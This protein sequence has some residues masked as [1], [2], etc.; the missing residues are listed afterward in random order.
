[1]AENTNA[2]RVSPMRTYLV[3]L[4]GITAIAAFFRYFLLTEIPPGLYPDEAMNGVDALR[5]LNLAD[6]RVFYEANN[7]REGLFMNIQAIAIQIFGVSAWTLRAV[8]ALFGTLAVPAVW[9]LAREVALMLLPA[10]H[11]DRERLA[12][13]FAL[14]SAFVLAAMTWHIHF[15]RIGFRAILLPLLSALT[16]AFILR[17]ERRRSRVDAVS[18]G[19]GFGLLF[20]T[21]IAA[22]ILPVLVIVLAIGE[23]LKRGREERR[24]L[25]LRWGW[26]LL[27]TAVTVLPLVGYFLTHPGSFTGRAGDVSVFTDPSPVKALGI[28]FG[29]AL[30]MFHIAGDWNWRHNVA[31]WPMLEPLIGLAFLIGFLAPMRNMFRSRMLFFAYA[32]FGAMLLPA[33][34]TIEGIPHA[35]RAF[36][37]VIPV[38]LFAAYG[39]M[40][41][42]AQLLQR[43]PS[44]GGRE[45]SSRML[46]TGL[47]SFL[48]VLTLVVTMHRYFFAWAGNDALDAAFRG[49]LTRAATWLNDATTQA[50]SR[51][52]IINEDGGLLNG[53]PMPVATIRYLTADD[54][55]ITYLT[56]ARIGEIEPVFGS[57]LILVTEPPDENLDAGLRAAF[58]S[59][60]AEVHDGFMTYEL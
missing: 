45:R 58:P 50:E 22:R 9:L 11:K 8:S 49:D 60:V 20:Y 23:W 32:W 29:K 36:G 39:V 28:S 5:A 12:E 55:S 59:A 40:W 48:I 15:S 14:V 25:L 18:A 33:V 38:A 54:P 37:V 47:A 16:F 51:Y 53:I 44:F 2:I 34:A 31:G 42:S 41:T 26:F 7:G 4:G 3:L 35:L 1:M 56:P 27:A 10:D 19:I 13:R 43:V 21:Y 17:A 52:V 57:T 24:A 46:R 30:G 6:F